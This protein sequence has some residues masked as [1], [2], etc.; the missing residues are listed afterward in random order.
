MDP[1][2]SSTTDTL[3][4]SNSRDGRCLTRVE[5]NFVA[6]KESKLIGR[7]SEK[8][9]ILKMISNEVSKDSEVISVWGMG[10]LGKT[11][12]VK[13]VYQSQELNAIFDKRACVA[14]KRRQMFLIV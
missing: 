1:G 5:T 3:D 14:V 9:R 6:F 10:G 12:L 7:E 4:D 11:T 13:D 2:P 8:S